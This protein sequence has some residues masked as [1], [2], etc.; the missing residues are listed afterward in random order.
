MSSKEPDSSPI[1]TIEANIL[2]NNL[3]SLIGVDKPSP[4]MTASLILDK[5]SS[6]TLF[7]TT[8]ET[9]SKA[10]TKVTPLDKRVDNVL[11][12]LETIIF[13]FSF[14]ITG[15]LSL[16]LLENTLPESVFK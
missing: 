2:G 4:L 1:L 16:S 9:T 10:C 14:F 12:N 5:A 13:W 11:V 6:A 3:S 15:I 7:P 8:S